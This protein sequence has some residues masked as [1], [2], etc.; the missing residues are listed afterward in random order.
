M[1]YIQ[2]EAN[3]NAY[4]QMSENCFTEDTGELL[5]KSYPILV[6]C[7]TFKRPKFGLSVLDA[8]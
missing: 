8:K 1:F 7:I 6:T 4:H 2:I 3:A 5:S